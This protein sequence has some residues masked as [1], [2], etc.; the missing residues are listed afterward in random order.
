MIFKLVVFHGGDRDIARAILADF[1]DFPHVERDRVIEFEIDNAE[2][3]ADMEEHLADIFG[4]KVEVEC[5]RPECCANCH[6]FDAG[7]CRRYP[8]PFPS[9]PTD[10]WCGEYTAS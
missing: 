3:V 9:V 10:Q 6:F 8:P 5:Y 7:A 4:S 2:R 1:T